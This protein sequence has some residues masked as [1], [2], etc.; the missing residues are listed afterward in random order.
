MLSIAQVVKRRAGASMRCFIPDCGPVCL[1]HGRGPR[2]DCA[3]VLQLS[4]EKCKE[5]TNPTGG[6]VGRRRLLSGKP[7][8][9][10]RIVTK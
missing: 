7:P 5:L 9:K 1:R 6:P 3:I 4:E 8:R 10:G 2:G